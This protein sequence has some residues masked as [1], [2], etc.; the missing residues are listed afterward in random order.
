MR[1]ESTK[2]NDTLRSLSDATTAAKAATATTAAAAATT[3]M[4]RPTVEADGGG[5]PEARECPRAGAHD[6]ALVQRGARDDDG[7]V[8]VGGMRNGSSA[9][10]GRVAIKL[11][12]QPGRSR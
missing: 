9:A 6:A 8:G 5:T 2:D 7:Y 10:E 4:M 1:H 11:D 3:T 12:S